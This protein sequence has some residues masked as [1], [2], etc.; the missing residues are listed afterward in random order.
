[1]NRPFTRISTGQNI[2]EGAAEP[3][4]RL[5]PAI[6]PSLPGARCT[7]NNFKEAALNRAIKIND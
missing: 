2:S 7:L 6:E 3:R 4:L 1:L 5:M